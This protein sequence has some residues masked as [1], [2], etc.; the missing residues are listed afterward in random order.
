MTPLV[1]GDFA[2]GAGDFVEG[3]DDFV[4]GGD[5]FVEG[6]DDFVEGGDD[7]VEG[8]GDFVEGGDDFVEGG[9]DFVEGGDDFVEGGGDFVEGGGDFVEGAD[10]LVSTGDDLMSRR[11]RSFDANPAKLLLVPAQNHSRQLQRARGRAIRR[12]RGERDRPAP[13][14]PHSHSP[15]FGGSLPWH[16]TARESR[17][18]DVADVSG[19]DRLTRQPP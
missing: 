1:L 18:A 14:C 10:D 9:D 6:G 5:D 16:I 12:H 4:E 7:F 11:A 15:R 13:V 17:L 2:G 3:S 8:G 19:H